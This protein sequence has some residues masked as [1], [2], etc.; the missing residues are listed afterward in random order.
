M[1]DGC[2]IDLKPNENNRFS[3]LVDESTDVGTLR[4]VAIVIS[5]IIDYY[6]KIRYGIIRIKLR[7]GY[8]HEKIHV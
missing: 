2:S 6:I 4:Y 3:L 1:R 5:T 7:Y 8:I